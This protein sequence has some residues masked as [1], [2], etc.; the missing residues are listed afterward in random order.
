MKISIVNPTFNEEE[1]VIPM[2]EAVRKQIEL[3]KYHAGAL[4][5]PGPSQLQKLL[6]QRV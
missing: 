1:N 3:L 5:H 2:Y 6:L 4:A